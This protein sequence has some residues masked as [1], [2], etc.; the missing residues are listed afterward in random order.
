MKKIF[1]LIIGSILLSLS[2]CFELD[3]FD[4][5]DSTWKGT[6]TDSYTNEPILA[7][8]ND[9]QMR[10]WER[11]WT[12]L[13]GGASNFQ[14]LRIKQDGTYQS[15]K[16]FPGT[17]DFLPYNG[18]FW[19]EDTVKNLKLDKTLEY[20]FTVTPYLQIVDYSAEMI[21]QE[22]KYYLKMA[23]KVKA[24]LLEKNGKALPRLYEIRPFISLTPYVGAGSN[25]AL[26]IP[27]YNEYVRIRTPGSWADLFASGPGNNTTSEFKFNLMELKKG[28]TYYVRGGACV[29]DTYRRFNYSPIVKIEVPNN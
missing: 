13:K 7:S 25:S 22:G 27:Q 8:Q 21:S 12:G 11:S 3:N 2:S 15:T 9:W 6:V 18:P 20:N 26:A 19:P 10:I 24:P 23:F 4:A 28:Y 14:D 29:D 16:L 1:L 17:Y 5:P